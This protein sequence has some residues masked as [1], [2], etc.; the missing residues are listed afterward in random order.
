MRL[1]I[2][3]C[4]VALVVSAGALPLLAL[5]PGSEQPGSIYSGASTWTPA[6]EGAHYPCSREWWNID[7][8]MTLDGGARWTLTSSFE[9]ERETPA[10]NLFLTLFNLSSGTSYSLGSYGDSIGTLSFETGRVNL[11]Y[12]AS[13]MQGS[14]PS[15]RVHF[16]R[17]NATI[18][19]YLNA[20]TP[21]KWVADSISSAVL[22]MGLGS[23]QYGFIPRCN[24]SG[25][26]TIGND[27]SRVTGTGYYEHV[28]GNW[29][30]STP[31]QSGSDVTQT[32][33]AYGQLAT[34][35]LS[36]RGNPPASVGLATGSNPFGYD[37]IWASFDNGWS[38]FYG[39]IPFWVC[40]GPAFGI[41]YLVSPDGRYL[42]FSDITFSYGSMEYASAYDACYPTAIHLTAQHGE[43]RIALNCAMACDVHTYLDTN[44]SS[45]FWEA[46]YLWESP[47][48]VTG[49]YSNKSCT[50]QLNGTCEIEPMRQVSMLGHNTMHI[51]LTLPPDGVG[52]AIYGTS[53]LMQF[54]AGI[55]VQVWS[56]PSLRIAAGRVSD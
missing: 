28:W 53:H 46:I 7:T 39:N 52:A 42:T 15:Y 56:E 48:P 37:W 17:G 50:M 55:A 19:L 36:H 34:W 11:S 51:S 31:M 47:G 9:Y 40:E 5:I 29:T 16:E 14:Y 10:C 6:D 27:S 41:L 45:S 13:W 35:W 3:C 26:M 12:G 32:A 2:V 30:Y 8:V 23:Y 38:M 4:L 44:L 49:V 18:D 24:V 33:R 21:P 1:L 43:H 54:K 25:T 20:T 22:P